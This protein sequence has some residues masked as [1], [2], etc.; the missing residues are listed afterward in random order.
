VT[1]DAKHR[2]DRITPTVTPNDLTTI[3]PQAAKDAKDQN[4]RITPTVTP[5]DLT[6]AR[7]PH[8]SSFRVGKVVAIKDTAYIT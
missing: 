8:P 5:N 6:Q 1:K 4:D 7:S 3:E 2:N